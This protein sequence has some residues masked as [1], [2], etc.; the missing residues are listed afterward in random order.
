[1]LVRQKEVKF[2]WQRICV[3]KVSCCTWSTKWI[4]TVCNSLIHVC[5]CW[6][7][8]ACRVQRSWESL[9]QA[10]IKSWFCI[11]LCKAIPDKVPTVTMEIRLK[12]PAIIH[13]MM[14]LDRLSPVFNNTERNT[15]SVQGSVK[16][17]G[18][19]NSDLCLT[20]AML[21]LWYEMVWFRQVYNAHAVQLTTLAN[22]SIL[23]CPT[24]NKYGRWTHYWIY[25]VL[26]YRK[27]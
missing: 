24:I 11:E 27:V 14:R 16:F 5:N 15:E 20:S 3:W 6:S 12:M 23:K 21:T 8:W 7:I 22:K 9:C 4:T 18:S 19:H 26:L 13:P 10:V 17:T 1:M 25:P 2:Q